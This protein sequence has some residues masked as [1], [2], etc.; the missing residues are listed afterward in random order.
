MREGLRG[1][2]DLVVLAGGSGVSSLGAQLT[3]IGFTTELA[4]LG[5]FAVAGLFVAAALGAVAGA[6]L[7][8]WAVDRFRNRPLLAGTVFAQVLLLVGLLLGHAHLPVLY[9]LIALLGLTGGIVRTCGSVLIPLTTGE[10]HAMRGYAWLSS[11]ENTGSVAGTVLGGLIA[12]GPGIEA[13]LV[14]DAVATLAHVVMVLRLRVDRDPRQDDGGPAGPTSPWSGLVLLRSD[15]LLLGRVAAQTVGGVAVAIALVN[16]VFL[17]HGPVGGNDFTYGVMLGCWTGGTLIGAAVSRRFTTARALVA[18]FATGNLVLGVAL[19][20]PALVPHA[21]VNGLA[22]IVA[23]ACGA[24]Q[25]VTLSGLV[26]VRT[27]DALRGRVF[28]TVGA[29]TAGAGTVGLVAAS[30]VVGGA[31]PRGALLVAAAFAALSGLM[32]WLVVFRRTRIPA[33]F[34]SYEPAEEQA[35][36]AADAQVDGPSRVKPAANA[37]RIG[38]K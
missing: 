2:R 38:T 31:G 1:N 20:A 10:D 37:L 6:P 27:P 4:G 29:V 13:A 33:P 17:V 30:A 22:W 19:V 9:G 26:R 35:D 3:L 16:E 18:A 28:A 25:N 23:G 36:G 11:A 7:A 14:L 32:A 24:V 21:V 34:E 12:V 5:A 15:R 8:G